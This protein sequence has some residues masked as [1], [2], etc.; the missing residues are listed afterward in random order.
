ML[1][2][3]VLAILKALSAKD[4]SPEFYYHLMA[5]LGKKKRPAAPTQ[6]RG[7]AVSQRTS[8]TVKRKATEAACSGDSSEPAARR[9]ATGAGPAS[10]QLPS[11][12][13]T[14]KQA[15]PES[16]MIYAAAAAATYTQSG[17]LKL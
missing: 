3:E 11:H 5:T 2:Q 7:T 16:G 13:A 4:I 17:P 9:P 10:Q 12:D 8:E 1:K 14:S 6:K 15:A